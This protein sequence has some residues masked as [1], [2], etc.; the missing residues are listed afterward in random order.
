MCT[1][2][3]VGHSSSIDSGAMYVIS[4]VTAPPAFFVIPCQYYGIIYT[5]S[6][7]HGAHVNWRMILA[8]MEGIVGIQACE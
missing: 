5:P 2:R 1:T 6:P 8:E 3:R 4:R 7:P